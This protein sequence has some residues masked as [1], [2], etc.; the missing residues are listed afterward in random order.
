VVRC[1]SKYRAHDLSARITIQ[2]KT[3]AADGM[4]GFTE[5]W[6]AIGQV[7]AMWK[8]L[9]GSERFQAMRITSQPRAR[10][11]IRFRGDSYGAPYYSA[12]DRVVYRNR[13]YNIESVI[14][15]DDAGDWL[16]LSLVEGAPS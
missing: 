16:E 15:V 5:A 14:D 11:I 4:G 12:A 13:T 8:P 9:S 7:W 1:C 2:R 6:T 3:Q 10:A